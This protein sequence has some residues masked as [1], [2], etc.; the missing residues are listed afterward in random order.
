MEQLSE[1]AK[2]ADLVSAHCSISTNATLRVFYA[3]KDLG[4]HI[5]FVGDSLPTPEV[6]NEPAED[7]VPEE[8]KPSASEQSSE[9]VVA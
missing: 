3:L 4:Y 9:E 1:E 8:D 6:E 5:E 7:I 2:L